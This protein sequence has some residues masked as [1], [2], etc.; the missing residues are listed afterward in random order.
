MSPL[1][2]A[3]I[4]FGSIAEKGH[5]PCYLASMQQGKLA[6]PGAFVSLPSR[7][8]LPRVARSASTKR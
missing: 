8:A 3:L 2:A 1:R 7:I 4:G 6:S 5:P